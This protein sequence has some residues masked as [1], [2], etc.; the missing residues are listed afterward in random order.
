M[1]FFFSVVAAAAAHSPQQ[2]TCVSRGERAPRGSDS[3]AHTRNS[4]GGRTQRGSGRCACRVLHVFHV[5]AFR[6]LL[7]SVLS[8]CNKIRG[9]TFNS[10]VKPPAADIIQYIP[11][12]LLLSLITF[13]IYLFEVG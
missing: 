10:H 8:D 4:A 12:L 11:K 6:S 2:S 7:S 5:R 13:V 3:T 9:R 1:V